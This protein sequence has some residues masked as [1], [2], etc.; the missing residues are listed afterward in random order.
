M[1]CAKCNRKVRGRPAP[2]GLCPECRG[3][4]VPAVTAAPVTEPEPDEPEQVEP[5]QIT[6]PSASGIRPDV[7]MQDYLASHGLSNV[8]AELISQGS[9][10]GRWRL[11][12]PVV[13]W[14]QA[15]ADALS[16]LGFTGPQHE[17]LTGESANGAWIVYVASPN[18][19]ATA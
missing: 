13:C 19:P 18:M 5:E 16:T 8:K 14:T 2:S 9:M 11:F 17:P 1:I 12:K 3:S 15:D 7:A 4:K 10:A 6:Q